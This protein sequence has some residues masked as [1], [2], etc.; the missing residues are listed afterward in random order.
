MPKPGSFS[1]GEETACFQIQCEME[2]SL[3]LLRKYYTK[4]RISENEA[5]VLHHNAIKSKLR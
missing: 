1:G 3:D 5:V 4:D 2:R